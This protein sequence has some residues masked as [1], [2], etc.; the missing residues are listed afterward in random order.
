MICNEDD[1]DGSEIRENEVIELTNVVLNKVSNLRKSSHDHESTIYLK[2][3][4]S[5]QS[6]CGR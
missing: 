2:K 6:A 3:K 4:R 1:Y 5:K